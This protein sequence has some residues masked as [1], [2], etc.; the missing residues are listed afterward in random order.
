MQKIILASTSPRRKQLLEMTGLKFNTEASDYEEDM[1]LKLKPIELAKKLSRGKA[2][3]VAKKHKNA[4][5][6]GADT[7]ISLGDKVLGKPHTP[8]RAKK[9][10]KEISGKP[11]RVITGFTVI[12]TATGRSI[13]KATGS[14]IYIKKLSS[15][16]IDSYVRT[17][18][19]LDKGGSYAIQGLGCLLVDKIEGD[20]LNIIGLPVKDVLEA[21]QKL[22]VKIL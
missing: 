5:V 13:S 15:K 4:I 11:H 3:A 9:M 2:E 22:G 16:I 6:I 17:G 10:L 7:F 19:P 8:E 12:N 18:E 1:S 14:R 21:M 20:Y